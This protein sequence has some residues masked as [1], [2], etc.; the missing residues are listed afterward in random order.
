[1]ITAQAGQRSLSL[2]DEAQVRAIAAEAIGQEETGITFKQI[3]L[4]NDAD[5]E[6]GGKHDGKDH[7]ER[8]DHQDHK[9]HRAEQA[10]QGKPAPLPEAEDYQ[11][12]AVPPDAS[13]VQPANPAVLPKSP[14]K[15]MADGA[16]FRPV[17]RVSCKV[18]EAKY[19]LRIDAVTGEVLSAK[20]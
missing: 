8:K 2:I 17:Y 6:Q 11:R 18:G 13:P 19:K 5:R 12:L 15:P 10:G 4:Q 20:A 3:A 9:A 16:D 1:M 14:A 7:K